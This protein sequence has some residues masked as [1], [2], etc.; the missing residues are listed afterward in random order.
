MIANDLRTDATIVVIDNQRQMIDKLAQLGYDMA[1]ISPRYNL[2]LNPFDRPRKDSTTSLLKYVFTGLME[3][4]LTPKQELIF[5][6]GCQLML[7]TP[8]ATINTFR[9][10]LDAHYPTFDYV[11]RLDPISQ[12]FF[13]NH[14][15]DKQYDQTKKEISWRVWS[16]LKNPLLASM[17]ASPKNRVNLQ[18][19]LNRKLILIDCDVDKL[20]EYT[21]FFGR[22]FIAQLLESAQF[23]FRGRHRPVYVYIDE[24]YYYFDQSIASMLETAR[25]GS[26]GLIL[27]H[28]YLDQITE[29]KMRSAIMSLTGTKFASKLSPSDSFAMAQA[30]RTT[31]EF[32]QYHKKLQ[33]ALALP[34]QITQSV[35]IPVGVIEGMP[36]YPIPHDEMIARYTTPDIQIEATPIVTI[37]PPAPIE[38]PPAP[39]PKPQPVQQRFIEPPKPRKPPG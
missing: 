7:V 35:N 36:K 5:E 13:R 6:F 22:Y 18:Q 16:L 25:K 4:P 10:L 37:A 20:H 15:W 31:P 34:D 30:M 23:R 33:F 26:I 17:F 39:P 3:S 11:D 38:T 24:A 12:D 29:P 28:Q 27:A 19:E 32:I 14:F 8:N 9:S 21:G 1:L 2:S